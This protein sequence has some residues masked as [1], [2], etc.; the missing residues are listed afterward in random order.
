[1][2]DFNPFREAKKLFKE[3]DT[4]AKVMDGIK[5]GV[6][7][8]RKHHEEMVRKG[9]LTQ[10]EFD[11]LERM[12]EFDVKE[13]AQYEDFS[14]CVE[15]YMDAK[16]WDRKTAEKECRAKN[17]SQ[18]K[19]AY[20]HF[21]IGPTPEEDPRMDQYE[22]EEDH[23]ESTKNALL[24]FLEKDPNNQT[25][26]KVKSEIHRAKIDLSPQG[27]NESLVRVAGNTFTVHHGTGEVKVVS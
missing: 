16:G 6:S 8:K 5:S 14:D 3:S 1:M 25:T 2:Y 26:K 23:K 19:E 17:Q 24:N 13:E 10:A 9:E 20:D 27:G 22:A 21:E 15:Y 4:F 7:N 11:R 18:F 12:G